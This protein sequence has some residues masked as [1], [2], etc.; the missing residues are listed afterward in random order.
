[1]L[2][3]IFSNPSRL[4]SLNK[5]FFTVRQA[6]T[7]KGRPKIS[8][9]DITHELF[10]V[11]RNHPVSKDEVYQ[12]YEKLLKNLKYQPY[13]VGVIYNTL[14]IMNASK[15]D[16][17]ELF[18]TLCYKF[19]KT[20]LE[21]YKRKENMVNC[22]YA[23]ATNELTKPNY[24]NTSMNMWKIIPK[25]IYEKFPPEALA[26]FAYISQGSYA[27]DKEIYKKFYDDFV[28]I[29]FAKQRSLQFYS[30]ALNEKS[31]RDHMLTN[32]IWLR[33]KEKVF[34]CEIEKFESVTKLFKTFG[35]L[36][37]LTSLLEIKFIHELT[38][39]TELYL[40]NFDV[41]NYS[42]AKSLIKFYA[43]NAYFFVAGQNIFNIALNKLINYDG[44]T[45]LPS[46]SVIDFIYVFAERIEDHKIIDD[47]TAKIFE[48]VKNNDRNHAE[49]IEKLKRIQYKNDKFW[50]SID[51]VLDTKAKTNKLSLQTQCEYLE[52]WPGFT[53]NEAAIFGIIENKA[54]YE[55]EFSKVPA[56]GIINLLN[57]ILK[58]KSINFNEKYSKEIIQLYI[59]HNKQ[60][61]DS[62]IDY[63]LLLKGI[64][65][66]EH[67]FK[68]K[69]CE[70]NQI[71]ILSDLYKVYYQQKN[72]D[73]VLFTS[74][75]IF[76]NS[77]TSNHKL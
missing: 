8:N 4:I 28:P 61:R 19:A 46:F 40:K 7:I 15:I 73:P 48:G 14:K 16:H 30:Y 25:N 5:F 66:I 54:N 57:H 24:M 33:F 42:T 18:D 45:K 12:I 77:I 29:L 43:S 37:K 21:H 75:E 50:E 53:I 35:N 41:I 58:N 67:E 64:F 62:M 32:E 51:N 56:E 47:L 60:I 38:K 1:M 63:H 34:E 52:K 22:A 13:S 9:E 74:I 55:K 26:Q 31:T 36:F 10:Q 2:I 65:K 72:K 17:A 59:E 44:L 23:I 69:L 39:Y 27:E 70:A 3:R 68:I 20:K 11:V 76:L 71:K 6:Q 49:A